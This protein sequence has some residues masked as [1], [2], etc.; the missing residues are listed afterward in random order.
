MTPCRKTSSH[1]SSSTGKGNSLA[2]TEKGYQVS[3]LVVIRK[4]EIDKE[5]AKCCRLLLRWN[6]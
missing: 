4:C 3:D 5:A 2:N 6:L 1:F